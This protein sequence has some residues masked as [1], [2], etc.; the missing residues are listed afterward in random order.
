[1]GGGGR[2]GRHTTGASAQDAPEIL[3]HQPGEGLRVSGLTVRFG[4]V[5]AVNGVDLHA[6]TGCIT[7]LI[8]PN[9]AGKTTTFNA[10]TGL[11]KP[12][13]GRISLR[14]RD[15]TRT[16]PAARGRAGVGRTFQIMDLCDS[17]SVADNVAL[18]HESGLAGSRPWAQLAASRAR[19]R[20]TLTAAADAMRL[21]GIAHL[22][23]RPAGE[24]STGERRLVELARCLAGRFDVL[25][26]DE[27]SSGLDHE[28]T[29]Q[30]GSVLQEVVRQRG[31]GILLVEHDMS[32]V[33]RVCSYIY[34][35]DFGELLFEGAP[36]QVRSSEV[37]RSAY[38]GEGDLGNIDEVQ[39]AQA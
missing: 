18:G 38:L 14:G 1:M 2:Y 8:G 15:I 5:T 12:D 30:F 36:E 29:A 25:L 39:E 34:V 26:L 9:G 31:V 20:E 4:G 13:S 32:L 24:L 37:V 21:C 16:S 11:I 6:P 35:L 23:D 33:M 7:G 17:L 19:R 28:E 10:G 22:A 27:P 3:E